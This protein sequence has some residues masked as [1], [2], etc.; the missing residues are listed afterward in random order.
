[1]KANTST[2]RSTDT[3]SSRGRTGGSTKEIGGKA[4]NTKKGFTSQQMEMKKKAF[5]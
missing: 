5:G 4:D 1:M 3:E 2:T